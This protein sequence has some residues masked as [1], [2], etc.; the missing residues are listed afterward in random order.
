[1]LKE[2]KEFAMRGNVVDMAVGIIIGAALFFLTTFETRIKRS[3]AL[4]AL[5]ELRSISH[6][7]DMHQLTKDP[8][9]IRKGEKKHEHL[10]N[11]KDL[12]KYSIRTL[13]RTLSM[14]DKERLRVETRHPGTLG[15]A[16]VD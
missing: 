16:P 8:E 5:E 11:S 4:D 14:K 7:I 9:L 1:M 10:N 13:F 6:V 15:L 12:L 2:F 3:K